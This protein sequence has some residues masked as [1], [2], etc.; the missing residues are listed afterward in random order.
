MS[1]DVHPLAVRD[2][3]RDDAIPLAEALAEIERVAAEIR[4]GLDR[5]CEC[6][7]Q[8]SPTKCGACDG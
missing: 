1:D 3:Q 8:G 5:A 7:A 4:R 2:V 6:R